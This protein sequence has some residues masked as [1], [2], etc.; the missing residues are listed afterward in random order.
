MSQTESV[1]EITSQAQEPTD[2]QAQEPTAEPTSQTSVKTSVKT[3]PLSEQTESPGEA[4]VPEETSGSVSD[5]LYRSVNY[6][7]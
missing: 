6:R 5:R 7:K 2:P 3:E 4:Y 1:P